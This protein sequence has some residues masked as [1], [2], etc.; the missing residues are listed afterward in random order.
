MTDLT[1]FQ[2]G[3]DRTMEAV[4]ECLDT[5]EGWLADRHG[6]CDPLTRAVLA[7]VR[8]KLHAITESIQDERRHEAQLARGR[9]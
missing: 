5:A 4:Y 8:S 1:E 6:D 2:R 7:L 9:G 3:Q